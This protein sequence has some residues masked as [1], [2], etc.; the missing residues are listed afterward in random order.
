MKKKT[1]WILLSILIVLV[2][3]FGIQRYYVYTMSDYWAEKDA[4]IIVAKQ[5]AG[6]ASVEHASKSVWDT[7]CWVIE[8]KSTSNQ[9]I[10]VWV[11]DGKVDHQELAKNGVTLEQ[12]RNKVKAELPDATIVRLVPGI[13]DKD[14]DDT[15]KEYVYQLFYKEKDHYNYR[16][17]KFSDGQA[18]QDTFTLP[19]R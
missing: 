5:Q 10:V 18:L 14:P 6:L 11:V 4:A 12:V 13:Y 7:V 15:A 8:G 16:F 19:N 9:D 17:Y 2:V 3:L 1:K